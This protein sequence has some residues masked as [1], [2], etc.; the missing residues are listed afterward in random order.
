MRRIQDRSYLHF[1]I[2]E[3]AGLCRLNFHCNVYFQTHT[4]TH[5]PQHSPP[6]RRTHRAQY[7]WF[8]CFL[9]GKVWWHDATLLFILIFF[10]TYIFSI[11]FIQY[12]TFIR[13]HSLKFLSISSS[14]VSS[15]RK[16]SLGCRVENRTRACLTASRRTTNWATP[17][18]NVHM[19][20]THPPQHTTSSTRKHRVLCWWVE[21]AVLGGNLCLVLYTSDGAM[22]SLCWQQC[23][24]P[25]NSRHMR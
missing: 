6:S 10:S 13:R 21:S 16:T 20:C 8:K 24:H 12:C 19:C 4:G 1:L 14:L 2:S 9:G 7:W 3:V 18:P 25:R 5:P 17:H 22:H 11:T 15:V 23:R